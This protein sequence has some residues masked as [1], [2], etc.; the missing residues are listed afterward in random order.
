MFQVKPKSRA[1]RGW[2]P[3]TGNPARHKARAASR[4]KPPVASSTTALTRP[5]A[6]QIKASH[7][8]ISFSSGS[9]V[10]VFPLSSMANSRRSWATSM[11]TKISSE[12]FLLSLPGPYE[13]VAPLGASPPAMVREDDKRL[14]LPAQCASTGSLPHGAVALCKV[15]RKLPATSNCKHTSNVFI[16]ASGRPAVEPAWARLS[17]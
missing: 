7:R 15:F 6:A 13:V 10:K 4:S 9:R 11:P 14:T 17:G 1:G 12:A 3:L 8:A 2:P 5:S 16:G